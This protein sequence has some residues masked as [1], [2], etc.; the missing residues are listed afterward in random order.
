MSRILSFALASFSTIMIAGGQTAT[1]TGTGTESPS[2]KSL[3]VESIVPLD[4]IN[5]VTVPSIPADVL[6][7]LT[8]GGRELHQQA[9]YDAGAKTLKVTGL[10]ENAGSAVPTPS[11][12]PGVTPVWSYTVTVDRVEITTKPSNAVVFVGSVAAGSSTT[13]FGDISG[14]LVT[15]SAGYKTPVDPV[16][17]A[18][19]AYSGIST[20]IAGA[21]SLFSKSG[22][23]TIGLGRTTATGMPTAVAGPKNLISP[24]PQFQLDAS[25]STDPNGGTLTYH[26]AYVGS[27]GMTASIT[28]ADTATPTVTVPDYSNAQGDYTFQLTVTNAAGLSSTD[29]VVVTYDVSQTPVF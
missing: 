11:D 21:A 23:G 27:F 18:N 24:T 8:S 26:W 10:L 15:F 3:S 29:T 7:S 19:T 4:G 5:A 2:L 20:N 22:A 28:G 16:P 12:P 1:T 13:P 6:V 25:K 14:A 9:I 17:V